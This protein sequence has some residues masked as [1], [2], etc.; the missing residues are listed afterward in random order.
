MR[1]VQPALSLLREGAVKERTDPEPCAAGLF[2]VLAS[3]A[4]IWDNRGRRTISY[5]SGGIMMNIRELRKAYNLSQA[6]LAEKL[7]VT[8][9][10]ISRLENGQMMIRDQIADRIWDVFG[11]EIAGG[12]EKKPVKKVK[13]PK[14]EIYI[15]SPLGGNITPE[16]VA[17]RMPEGTEACFVRVDQN[18]IW[19]VRGEETG[20]VEI[21]SDD[22]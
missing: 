13:A 3:R 5:R 12:E 9:K 2:F 15:Q 18:L 19:W 10:T 6:A 16:E 17:A 1:D 11:V 4:D 20:A 22:R 21:W 8:A 7:G 14:L